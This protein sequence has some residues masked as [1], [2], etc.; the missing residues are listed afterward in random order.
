MNTFEKRTEGF[1]KK[2]ALDEEQKFKAEVRRNRLLGLWAAER[3]GITGDAAAAYANEVVA[4]DFEEAGDADVVRKLMGDLGAK[5]VVV[6]DQAIR[7][8]M[9]DFTAQVLTEVKAGK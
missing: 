9:N 1:E 4:A 5:G 8:K 2:F 6:T 7:A 3:M